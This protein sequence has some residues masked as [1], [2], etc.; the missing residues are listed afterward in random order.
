[1][2]MSAG[3]ETEQVDAKW[4]LQSSICYLLR[5]KTLAW[6]NGNV[7]ND[8]HMLIVSHH[9]VSMGLS[10]KWYPWCIN[11]NRQSVLS[12]C[13]PLGWIARI[14]QNL[15]QES[16]TSSVQS[17]KI[18]IFKH[19]ELAMHELE[20][21]LIL[22]NVLH[23]DYEVE[24]EPPLKDRYQHRQETEG[25]LLNFEHISKITSNNQDKLRLA[26]RFNTSVELQPMLSQAVQAGGFT[27]VK[28]RS[29]S[30]WALPMPFKYGSLTLTL[31]LNLNLDLNSNV[32][33]DT[34]LKSN[35]TCFWILF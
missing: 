6:A 11:H 27:F 16:C 23:Q 2:L 35:W 12:F 10:L 32:E 1:M 18:Q 5:P 28:D 7:A 34:K 8:R 24:Q 19:V 31:S 13:F 20:R 14:L 3:F 33:S 22:R 4:H 9:K 17:F 25:T 26:C 30:V 15:D 21:M 29:H